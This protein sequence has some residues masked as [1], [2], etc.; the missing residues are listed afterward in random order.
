MIDGDSSAT[1]ALV[2]NYSQRDFIMPT[3]Q[4]MKTPFLS[5]QM[6]THQA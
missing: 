4:Q 5:T 1:R 3:P 6:I 2:G